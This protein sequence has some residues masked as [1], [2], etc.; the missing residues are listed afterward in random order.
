MQGDSREIKIK[1]IWDVVKQ[2]EKQIFEGI[3]VSFASGWMIT[4]IIK[5][6]YKQ[7]NNLAFCKDVNIF[8]LLLL[9]I[10]FSA[11]VGLIYIKKSSA[12]RILMFVSVYMFVLMCAGNITDIQWVQAT[13]NTIGKVCYVA[14]LGFVAALS[15]VYVKKDIFDLFRKITINITTANILVAVTGVAIFG[16]VGY[17]TVMRYLTYS[18]TTFDFGIFAQMYEYMR[19][20]G[21]METTLERGKLLSHFGVHFSP[22]FYIMLPVYFIFPSPVTVQL[23]QAFMIALPVIP[24]VLLC[25]HYKMSH[26]M[27]IAM[28]V[29]YALYP[30]TSGGAMYDIHE[31]CFLT[32]LILMSIWAIEKKKDLWIIVFVLLTFLVKEDAAF[33]ILIIGT[34]FFVSRREKQRGL[35][36]IAISLIYFFIAVSIVESYGLGIMENRFNNLY[37]DTQNGNLWQI[38]QTVLSNPGYA[39]MQV[40]ADRANNPMKKIEYILTMLV[41][42]GGILMTVKRKYSKFILFIPF[43]LF[44]LLPLY[45]YMH[46]INFQYNFGVIA[47][48][49]YVMIMNLSSVKVEKAKTLVGVGIICASLLF[50]ATEYPRISTYGLRYKEN[51]QV[52]EQINKGIELIPKDASVRASGFMT[53]HLASNLKVYDQDHKDDSAPYYFLEEGLKAD[54]LVIDKRAGYDA[55][56]KFMKELQSGE[57]EMIYSAP[58]AVEIYKRK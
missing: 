11:I 29:L 46:D 40:I 7:T 38:I 32:F 47:L 55:S 25:R 45:S 51:K 43:V 44:T 34:Y 30:A 9:M 19:S 12:A 42:I 2:K 6:A 50:V 52:Y 23:I 58:S 15:F 1:N 33:Y 5:G 41:P 57:Y 3:F 8:T 37:Y 24:I 14:A 21:T 56:D 49:M 17:V 10:C 27:A 26:W 36:L 31:N 4:S 16:F 13:S 53:P 48:F 54:Y 20:T 18:N 35:L 39:L 22:I 28:T